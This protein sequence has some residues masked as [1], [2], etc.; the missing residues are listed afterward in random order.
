MDE[1]YQQFI[2][3][4]AKEAEAA[5]FDLRNALYGANDEQAREVDQFRMRIAELVHEYRV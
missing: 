5:L 3:R 4:N 2:L 1:K